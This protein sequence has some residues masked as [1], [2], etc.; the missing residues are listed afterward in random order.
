MQKNRC[1][2]P[3]ENQLKYSSRIISSLLSFTVMS[4]SDFNRMFIFNFSPT[5]S[6]YLWATFAFVPPKFSASGT[7]FGLYFRECN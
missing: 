6:P 1:D 2:I 7:Y 4:I 3:V 5:A